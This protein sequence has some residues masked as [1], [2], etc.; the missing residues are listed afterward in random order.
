MTTNCLYTLPASQG[1]Y[2]ISFVTK[3]VC[4]RTLKDLE[5]WIT[6]GAAF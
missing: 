5:A 6:S 3:E 2:N 1:V 4:D